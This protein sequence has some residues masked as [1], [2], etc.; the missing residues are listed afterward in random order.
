MKKYLLII[1]VV[2]SFLLLGVGFGCGCS[3]ETPNDAYAKERKILEL[4]DQYNFE[5]ST[6]EN[7]R[8]FDYSVVQKLKTSNETVNERR[9][10]VRVDKDRDFATKEE[11]KKEL[12]EDVQ[13]DQF[14]ESTILFKYKNG[15]ASYTD[16][17][18]I[19]NTERC[20]LNDFVEAR[21]SSF[22][23]QL[24]GKLSKS[25]ITE[26]GTKYILRFTIDDPSSLEFSSSVSNLVVTIVVDKNYSKILSVKMSYDQS[27]TNITFEFVPYYGNVDIK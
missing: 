12:N 23:P 19:E 8:G 18:G 2:V 27:L 21:I 7:Y 24:S 15:T 26:M 5:T 17:K 3:N 14:I 16:E 4:V 22:L 6:I 20:T 25:K 9:L 11:Y 1:I 10:V 13:G